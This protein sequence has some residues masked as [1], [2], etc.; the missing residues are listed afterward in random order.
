MVNQNELVL[1]PV[2]VTNEEGK[3]KEVEGIQQGLKRNGQKYTVRN[4]RSR[5][6]FPNEWFEFMKQIRPSLVRLHDDGNIEA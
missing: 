6:F 3:E 5:Y 4:S 1:K 2:Y